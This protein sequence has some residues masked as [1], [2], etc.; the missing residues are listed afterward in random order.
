MTTAVVGAAR[1]AGLTSMCEMLRFSP[2]RSPL[3]TVENEALPMNSHREFQGVADMT[4][5]SI[6][7]LADI[8]PRFSSCTLLR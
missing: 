3:S 8:W 1:P 2:S 4:V 7:V 6:P 5:D